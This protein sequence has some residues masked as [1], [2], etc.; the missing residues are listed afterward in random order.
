MNE[1]ISTPRDDRWHADLRSALG[2]RDSGRCGIELSP[3]LTVDVRSLSEA[4]IVGVSESLTDAQVSNIDRWLSATGHEYIWVLSPWLYPL[5]GWSGDGSWS[6][7]H[8]RLP[9]ENRALVRRAKLS[10]YSGGRVLIGSHFLLEFVEV[11]PVDIAENR[12]QGRGRHWS[13][14]ALRAHVD[15]A[16]K[17][18]INPLGD[19]RRQAFIRACPPKHRQTAL[20]RSIAGRPA[21]PRSPEQ[22]VATIAADEALSP[23]ASTEVGRQWAMWVSE[24][25]DLPVPV[26]D[27]WS[28]LWWEHR[29]RL[30]RSVSGSN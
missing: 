29:Q 3:D 18:G 25:C 10:S 23:L 16:D 2:I 19:A 28:S 20:R 26:R 1:R 27:R 15:G 5:K 12:R 17:P 22:V 14:G 21:R 13:L 24:W 6:L 8:R 4:L 30:I 11:D 9:G 7:S